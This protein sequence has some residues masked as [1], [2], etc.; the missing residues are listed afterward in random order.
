[1]TIDDL[2]GPLNVSN[3][4]DDH[5]HHVGAQADYGAFNID[6]A[7]PGGEVQLVPQAWA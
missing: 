6:S 4:D 1:M 5:H 7:S 2:G 3:V